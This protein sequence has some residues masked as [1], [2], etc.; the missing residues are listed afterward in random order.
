M[1]FEKEILLTKEFNF[2]NNNNNNNN[3]EDSAGKRMSFC[4]QF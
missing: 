4:S 3:K 2:F 1:Q